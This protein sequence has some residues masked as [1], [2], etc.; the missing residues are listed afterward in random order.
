MSTKRLCGLRFHFL[1]NYNLDPLYRTGGTLCYRA[2]P[3]VHLVAIQN[4]HDIDGCEDCRMA[5]TNSECSCCSDNDKTS[6][7]FAE[8]FPEN[9][10]GSFS[11]E[12]HFPASNPRGSYSPSSATKIAG[13]SL[14]LDADG[15]PTGGTHNYKSDNGPGP[16]LVANLT[17]YVGEGARPPPPGLPFKSSCMRLACP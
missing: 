7:I 10:S 4:I 11:T 12:L 16:W 17:E 9:A 14:A 13:D 6:A 15:D 3:C 8:R 1:V 2:V 5:V